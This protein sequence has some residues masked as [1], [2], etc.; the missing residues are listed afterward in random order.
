MNNARR[1]TINSIARDLRLV[2]NKIESVKYEEEYYFDSMPEN[3]QGSQRG[4]ESQDA[5]ESLEDTVDSLEEAI[6]SIEM[7]L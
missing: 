3:L 6:E 4:E 5:I 7:I 1:R 2:L